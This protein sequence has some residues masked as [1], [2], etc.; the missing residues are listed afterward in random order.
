V[1]A[2]SP[3]VL[4]F[5]TAGLRA[6][7][8][9][10]PGR[11]NTEVVR[12]AATAIASELLAHGIGG[13]PSSGPVVVG[14]DARHRSAAFA[15]VAVRV[16][17]AHG[18]SVARFDEPVPTP[19]VAFAV[20]ELR[21]AAGI[22]I[23]ASHNPAGDNGLKLYG[24]DGAQIVP[25]TDERTEA[26]MSTVGVDADAD[27]PVS[28]SASDVA[29][30]HGPSTSNPLVDRYLEGVDRLVER[31]DGRPIGTV[32]LTVVHSALH[33]VGS[34]LLEAVLARADGVE[35]HPVED[36]RRPDPD[37]PTVPDPNP[38]HRRTLDR[39]LAD[40]TRWAADLA[41]ALDP[42]ADRLAA[43]VPSDGG[44]WRVLTGDELGAVL[45]ADRLTHHRTGPQ[46]LVATT[47]VSS[48][49]VPTMCAAAGVHH[50]E[51]ATGFKWL[52]RP[53]LE[54]E[55]LHQVMLY[56]EALGY[57][58]GPT[59]RDKDGVAAARCLIA[60]VAGLRAEGRSVVQLLD[61]LALHH[62]AHVTRNGSR[63]RPPGLAPEELLARLL[64]PNLSTLA[65]VDVVERDRPAA[66][67]ARLR[68]ADR[69]RI[70][71]R[72]SGTEPKSKYYLEV[73]E[74]VTDGDVVA[75]RHRADTRLDEVRS[76]VLARI[77]QS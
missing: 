23:T 25:P 63:P 38:E 68:L 35:Q 11:M 34:T 46:D 39:L 5:G 43:A 2:E 59:A 17:G 58:I 61:E 21:A 16:L 9:D 4:R 76:A 74:P 57:G 3:D 53:A 20:Q 49:L 66:D 69:T 36:Q 48:Q 41:I 14:H 30:L 37:F 40:A 29:L 77:E 67:T 64:D 19:L 8:G 75:A 62:G 54:D 31:R 56:E 72:P 6:P 45:C 52:C 24:A 51:T 65:G 42:D 71:L 27:D 70:L 12:R 50:V 7:M 44:G 60:A 55:A 28:A 18:I 1:T 13:P 26:R 73:V 10:G 33:G 15:D 32:P 47:F 22:V